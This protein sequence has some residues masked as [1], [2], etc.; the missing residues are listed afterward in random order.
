MEKAK[1][2]IGATAHQ[3]L[4]SMPSL[5]QAPRVVLDTLRAFSA[6]KIR[7]TGR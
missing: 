7:K 4:R 1:I 3:A 2:E 5:I 6:H